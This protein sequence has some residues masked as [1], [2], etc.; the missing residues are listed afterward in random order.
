MNKVCANLVEITITLVAPVIACGVATGVYCG[1]KEVKKQF[2]KVKEYVKEKRVPKSK[3]II[4][5]EVYVGV[6]E[7]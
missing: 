1:A 5:D 6:V 3:V 7:G 4:D 2:N